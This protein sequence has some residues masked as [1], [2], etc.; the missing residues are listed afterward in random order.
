MDWEEFFLAR[1]LL[2]EETVGQAQREAKAAEDAAFRDTKKH[3]P[4]G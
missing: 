3:L 1:Q 4:R 2:S